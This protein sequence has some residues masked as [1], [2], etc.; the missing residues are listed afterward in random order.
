VAESPELKIVAPMPDTTSRICLLVVGMHRS[1]TSALTR[2][3]NI[4]GASAPNV[5]LGAEPHNEAGHWEPERIVAIHE[6]MLFR[7]DSR[8]DDWRALSLDDL[9]ARDRRTYKAT[10]ARLLSEEFGT[11]RLFV[12][13]DPRICRFIPLYEELLDSARIEARF[14]LP[15]RNP[16]EVADSLKARDKISRGYAGLLWLRHTLDAE[17][18]TRGKQ[19][20]LSRYEDLMIDFQSELQRIGTDLN[21][22]WP[23][24]ISKAKPKLSEHFRDDLK[25]QEATLLELLASPDMPVWVKDAYECF[26]QLNSNPDDEKIL[27]RL[28][29][30]RAEFD[31]ACLSLGVPAFDEFIRREAAWQTEASELKSALAAHRKEIEALQAFQQE[32]LALRQRLDQ[33]SDIIRSREE[34]LERLRPLQQQKLDLQERLS[35][36]SKQIEVR[37]LE[38]AELE[39]Q[40]DEF[41]ARLSDTETRLEHAVR[42]QNVQQAELDEAQTVRDENLAALAQTNA[43]LSDTKDQLQTLQTALGVQTAESEV[44]LAER[45]EAL[46]QSAAYSEQIHRLQQQ[47]D[48]ARAQ[49][50][51]WEARVIDTHR[52]H[53]TDILALTSSTSWK[54][55]RPIRGLKRLVSEPGFGANLARAISRRIFLALPLSAATKRKVRERYGRWRLLRS[56]P[57]MPAHPVIPA[58]PAAPLGA[59]SDSAP[60]PSLPPILEIPA[61]GRWNIEF[62]EQNQTRIATLMAALRSPP[63]DLPIDPSELKPAD[64]KSGKLVSL[65]VRTHGNRSGLLSR[66][67]HSIEAQE[68]RPIE[69]IITDDGGLT[70][71]KLLAPFEAVAGLTVRLIKLPKSGRSEAANAGLR[72]ATGTY[73]GFLDDD[74]YLLPGHLGRL[75]GLLEAR[76]DLDA[77]YAGALE[78]AADLDPE[79]LAHKDETKTAI[80]F[81]PVANSAELLDR[82]PFPIQ[83]VVFRRSL[84]GQ[85]DRFDPNLDALE[86]WLFWMRLLCGKKVGGIAEVT[87][88]FY[89]PKSQAAHERRIKSHIAAEPYFITQRRALYEER[90][91]SDI[92]LV[93][94]RVRELY[95]AAAERAA[96]PL[97]I[98]PAST[99]SAQPDTPLHQT[100]RARNIELGKPENK[101]RVVAYTSINLRYLPK[102]LAWAKSV[103]AHNPDWE[104]HILLNDA[105]PKDAASW[106]NI[107]RVFPI[108]ALEIPGFHA[109][110]FGMRVVE[111]CTATKPFY[112]RKLLDAGYA[113]VFFFD[114]DTHVYSDLNQLIDEFGENSVLITPHCSEDAVRDA[115]IHYNEISSLAHGVFNLGFLGLRNSPEAGQVIDFWCRRLIRHCVDDHARG[116][117]TDQKWFNLVP[118]FFEG[119]KVLK[120]RGCNTASWNIARRPVTMRDGVIHA[121]CDPLIFFHFSGYDKN[122]PRTLFDIFG[123]YNDVLEKL[124]EDYDRINDQ[125]SSRFPVWKQEWSLARYDNGLEIPDAHREIFKRHYQFQLLYAEPFF[126]GPNSFLE[127]MNRRNP[128][129]LAKLVD[130]P[131][132]LRRYY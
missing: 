55:T 3:L 26:L 126:A 94:A 34:E 53:T 111:L 105:L 131:G 43:R 70:D 112:A 118:V 32:S 28:D 74:D 75:C 57:Q 64:I 73:I 45:D 114:P 18:A 79:T 96:R 8:W 68:Y 37:N 25:H 49:S 52:Q 115:E 71:A 84:L 102:A 61:D 54:L 95:R 98:Q 44:Y 41:A 67:L 129:E 103:K 85:Q 122:V 48:L 27:D 104:T 125:F 106:P 22:S 36:L 17:A 69:V 121:G 47:L 16:L 38:A 81:R 119:V 42:L 120:H 127:E 7:A 35:E 1:G 12:L 90:R 29:A 80:F 117:F 30:I 24:P 72:E 93:H 20:T 50:K 33:S 62:F 107:D 19:R 6:E 58:I 46:A 11:S 56:R 128:D 110:A 21:L 124:I 83:T 116:L 82:N 59:Q 77:A 89:V 123:R 40:K 108:S 113:H 13:K 99:L 87:S 9:S 91:L 4:L 101:N 14:L 31:A 65:I 92:G 78:I 63:S 109:W 5:V 51:A 39:R 130:P 132:F 10:L 2:A 60:R 97:A 66:A 23:V 86:D 76:S 88:A 15:F 100:I